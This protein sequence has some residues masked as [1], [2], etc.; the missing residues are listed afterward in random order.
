[1]AAE[2]ELIRHVLKIQCVYR[3]KKARG[4][5]RVKRGEA[6]VAKVKNDDP[7]V[8]VPVPNGRSYYFHRETKEVVGL[9]LFLRR[10]QSKL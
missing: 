1:M 10:M 7:W 8:E 3:S 5:L 9:L 4:Q 6:A 2:N